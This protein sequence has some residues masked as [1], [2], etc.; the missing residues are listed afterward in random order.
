MIIIPGKKFEDVVLSAVFEAC[1]AKGLDV[2]VETQFDEAERLLAGW[3]EK[4]GKVSGKDNY[5]DFQNA[6]SQVAPALSVDQLRTN[7]KSI[8]SDA[9]ATFQLAFQEM[10]GGMEFQPQSGNLIPIL[11]KLVKSKSFKDRFK[12]LAL[13]YDEFGFTLEKASFSKDVLQG[14]ME[15]ICKNEPNVMFIGCIHKDFKA[16]ADQVQ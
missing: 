11:K 12:G 15:T 1:K 13:F 3:E 4:S 8:D 9:L 6:L 16:Y 14:F 5:K 7:L 2:E 10:M